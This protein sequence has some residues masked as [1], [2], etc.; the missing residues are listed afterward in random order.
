[1]G[2]VR[3]AVYSCP[4]YLSNRAALFL[5]CLCLIFWNAE[6]SKVC[7]FIPLSFTGGGVLVRS[8]LHGR[9][10]VALYSCPNLRRWIVSVY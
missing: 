7:R 8:G 1:M 2:F 3:F 5:S 9:I 10:G 6:Y 4:T